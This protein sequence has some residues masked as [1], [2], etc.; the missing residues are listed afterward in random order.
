MSESTEKMDAI[1]SA[2]KNKSGLKQRVYRSTQEVFGEMKEIARG[3]AAELTR[4]V[5]SEDSS[6]T[7]TFREVN[8]FEFHLQFSGDLLMFSM[9][10]NVVT[11]PPDHHLLRTPYV[12]ENPDRGFFG[13]IMV[14]NFMSDTIRYNRMEDPGY[15]LAR[16]LLNAEK[17]FS[18]EG[19]R[20]LSFLYPEFATNDVTA[21]MLQVFMETMM[22]VAIDNDL[23]APPYQDILLISLGEKLANQMVGTGSKVG[24][25]MQAGSQA[26]A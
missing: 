9:H 19:I 23:M 7:I 17:K 15:L 22:L 24:F 11:F 3:I 25:Q 18:V 4:R 5:T 16:I 14:Y 21:E 26:T 8:D 6:V 10:S 12:K 20:Q 13:H 2:L 1:V